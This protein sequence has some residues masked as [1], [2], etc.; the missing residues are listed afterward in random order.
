M[1]RRQRCFIDPFG[2]AFLR[3]VQKAIRGAWFFQLQKNQG[4]H[5]EGEG[6]IPAEKSCRG[7]DDG[8]AKK[9]CRRRSRRI[10]QGRRQ[11][12]TGATPVLGFLGVIGTRDGGFANQGSVG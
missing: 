10:A 11:A 4:K 6:R 12:A 7:W 9:R 5:R 3:R 8:S 2:A 1:W